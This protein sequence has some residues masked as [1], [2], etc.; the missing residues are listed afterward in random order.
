MADADPSKF[1]DGQIMELGLKNFM[2]YNS[3]G[4]EIKF[5]PGFNVILGPNGTG[6]P[7]FRYSVVFV[8]ALV[9]FKKNFLC[10]FFK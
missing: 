1:C 4:V 6:K 3:D 8:K 10:S 2:T 7:T 9:L 5:K